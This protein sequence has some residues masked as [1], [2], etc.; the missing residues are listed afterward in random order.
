MN[1]SLTFNTTTDSEAPTGAAPGQVTTGAPLAGGAGA[2][3]VAQAQAVAPTTTAALAAPSGGAARGAAMPAAPA[4]SPA[5]SETLGFATGR[6]VGGEQ[7]WQ[8]CKTCMP[9]LQLTCQER[10]PNLSPTFTLPSRRRPR[11]R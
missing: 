4:A 8:L 10:Q 2:G 7:G 11:H 9:L 5:A 3:N 1:A 6:L